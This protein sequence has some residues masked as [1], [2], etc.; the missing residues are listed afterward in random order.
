MPREA[1]GGAATS[2]RSRPS[3]TASG[4]AAW[5]PARSSRPPRSPRGR[6]DS[7]APARRASSDRRSSLR[8]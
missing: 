1:L 5:R 8:L 6:V 2:R 4:R 3:G 7:K